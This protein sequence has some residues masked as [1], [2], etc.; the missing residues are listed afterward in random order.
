MPATGSVAMPAYTELAAIRSVSDACA[1]RR[2][3]EGRQSRSRIASC[4]AVKHGK[5]DERT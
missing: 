1:I 5:L 4:I 3:G 2:V